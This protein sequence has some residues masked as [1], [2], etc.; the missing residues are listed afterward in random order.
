MKIALPVLEG[1][2]CA[3]FGHCETFG[4]VEVNPDTKEILKIETK[5][6][7]EGVSCKSAD[8]IAKQGVSVVLAGGMGARP[9]EA[10]KMNNVKV[11]SGCEE[12]PIE[13]IVKE[14]LNSTLKTGENQCQGE[15]HDH[16]HCHHSHKCNHHK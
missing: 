10:F 11:I 1:K 15:G 6:P 2:L 9:M 16:T 7:Q 5:T 12:L 14:Y 8:W 4:F 13:Q 3:H